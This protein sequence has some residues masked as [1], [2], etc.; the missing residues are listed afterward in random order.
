MRINGFPDHQDHRDKRADLVCPDKKKTARERARRGF[1]LAEMLITVAIIGILA[2]FGFVAVIRYQ[3]SLKQT[4]L[5]DTAR[6][7]FVAAQNHMTVSR[8]SGNW[9]TYVAEAENQPG[10]V[11]KKLGNAMG[12]GAQDSS[13]PSDYD[14]SLGSWNAGWADGKLEKDEAHDF[15]YVTV[16]ADDTNDT[17]ILSMILPNDAIDETLRG[18]GNIIIEYDSETVTV[19][20]V[21]YCKPADLKKATY[22]NT[23]GTSPES[24]IQ[25][26]ASTEAYKNQNRTSKSFRMKSDPMVGYYGGGT[27]SVK[28]G[29]VTEDSISAIIENDDR[30][31]LQVAVPEQEKSDSEATQR[32]YTVKATV[33]GQTS[34]NSREITLGKSDGIASSDKSDLKGVIS[35]TTVKNKY[36]LYFYTLDSV[37]DGADGHFAS[38][39]C[40]SASNEKPLI[41]G[42]NLTI[43]VRLVYD[44]GT[45][46][47][48]DKSGTGKKETLTAD[49]VGNS[50]TLSCNS[51]FANGSN[52]G[53]NHTARIAYGRH[54]QNLST[55]VSGVNASGNSGAQV[56][57]SDSNSS[58]IITSA[59]MLRDLDWSG[60]TIRFLSSEAIP[61]TSMGT[62]DGGGTG[63]AS[64]AVSSYKSGWN[65]SS[66]STSGST[67]AS[68]SALTGAG[69]FYSISNSALTSF[70]GNGF[71]ISNLKLGAASD[72]NASGSGTTAV[73]GNNG[74]KG[75]TYTGLFGN[76]DAGAGTAGG[77]KM[78]I[79]RLTLKNPTAEKASYAGFVV[80]KTSRVTKIQNV[81][82]TADTA[83]N[84]TA[85]QAAGGIVGQAS[86]TGTSIWYSRVLSGKT[87]TIAAISDSSS[88]ST[89]STI[90]SAAGG[91]LGSQ[92]GSQIESKTGT[93]G[94]GTG[95]SI[96]N[97]VVSIS[98]KESSTSAKSGSV[99]NDG[100]SL[101][102]TGV[103]FAGGVL[104]YC[105]GSE[106]GSSTGNASGS[107]LPYTG[108]VKINDCNVFGVGNL[109]RVSAKD[110]AAGLAAYISTSGNLDVENS[111]TSI[112]VADSDTQVNSA[113]DGFGGLIG[114][115]NS[116]E[117][118]SQISNCYVGG[119]TAGGEYKEIINDD[120]TQ[121]RYNIRGNGHVGG[122]IG[123]IAGSNLLK[124]ENCFTTA[125]AYSGSTVN[126]KN[127]NGAGTNA[128]AGSFIA[129][130]AN[131]N[132]SVTSCYATGLTNGT[133]FV[134]E[135]GSSSFSKTENNYYL[136]G[137]NKAKLTGAN[138]KGAKVGDAGTPFAKQTEVVRTNK[139]DASLKGDYPYQM[140][141]GQS[142]YYGDWVVPK[143]TQD[144]DGSFGILY[145]EIVQHGDKANATKS[146]YYHGFVGNAVPGGNAS[147]VSYKEIS[148]RTTLSD[149]QSPGD[150]NDHGLLEAPEGGEYVTE[151]GYILL[152]SDECQDEL[153]RI[154]WEEDGGSDRNTIKG[155]INDRILIQYDAITEQL[156]L[157]G[158]HAYYFN[159]ENNR[160]LTRET[161]N[162]PLFT[163]TFAMSSGTE[164]ESYNPRIWKKIISFTMNPYLADYLYPYGEWSTD[165]Q[166][167]SAHQLNILFGSFLNG[168]SYLSDEHGGYKTVTQT[169]DISYSSEI[170]FT[171]LGEKKIYKSPQIKRLGGTYQ[172]EE[173][174][175]GYRRLE[176]LS[177]PIFETIHNNE[178]SKFKNFEISNM[179][180]SSVVVNNNGEMSNLIVSHSK[181]ENS[182]LASNQNTKTILNC[183]LN[184][185]SIQGN[186]VA[187]SNSGLISNVKI[188]NAFIRKNGFVNVNDNSGTISNGEIKNAEIGDNGVAETN[189]GTIGGKN[190]DDSKGLHLESVTIGKNGFVNEN[191]GTISNSG[192]TNAQIKENGAV[193]TNSGTI[194]NENNNTI[195]GIDLKFVTIGSN[196][197]VDNN[198]G[199]IFNSE[200]VNAQI[201]ENGFANTNSKI[202]KNCQ[203]YSDNLSYPTEYQDQ[204]KEDQQYFKPDSPQVD[205]LNS[206]SKGYNLLACGL[207]YMKDTASDDGT[208]T[209]NGDIAGFVKD[210][211]KDITSCSYSGKVFGG[212]VA[213]GFFLNNSGN[214]E[215][216]YANA[217]VTASGTVAGFGYSCTGGT[218]KLCHSVGMLLQAEEGA[219][220]LYQYNN[221]SWTEGIQNDYSATWKSTVSNYYFFMK[222]YQAPGNSN[223]INNC[224]YLSSIDCDKNSLREIESQSPNASDKIKNYTYEKLKE[225][226]GY[227]SPANGNTTKPYYQYTSIDQTVYPFPMPD[228]MIAYGDWSWNKAIYSIRFEGNG[229]TP[230]INGKEISSI[231]D[232]DYVID[233]TLPDCEAPAGRNWTFVGWQDDQSGNMYKAG[234]KVSG[235]ATSGIVMLTAQWKINNEKDFNYSSNVVQTYTAQADGW[236]KLEVWGADGGNATYDATNYYAQGG[237]GGYTVNYVYLTEGQEIDV[238]VG[239]RGQ[240]ATYSQLNFGKNESKTEKSQLLNGGWNG[241]GKSYSYSSKDGKSVS[242]WL[243]GSGGGAS[244]MSL[245][246]D[247]SDNAPKTLADYSEQ[248]KSILLVAGGGGGAGLYVNALSKI[249]D[250]YPAANMGGNGGGNPGSD[251]DGNGKS[252]NTSD[253]SGTFG[254]GGTV[255]SGGIVSGH[256]SKSG[257]FGL[258]GSPV[259]DTDTDKYD[260]GAGGG[261]GWYGGGSSYVQTEHV[262]PS[263]GGGS[264]YFKTSDSTFSIAN[265]TTMQG[266]TLVGGNSN[267]PTF[268]SSDNGNGNGHG[269]I[270]YLPSYS[271]SVTVN[272]NV[273]TPHENNAVTV[274][275]NSQIQIRLKNTQ[276]QSVNDADWTV[277]VIYGNNIPSDRGSLAGTGNVRTF[278]SSSAGTYVITATGPEKVVSASVTIIVKEAEGDDSNAITGNA[279]A[280]AASG[281]NSG[282]TANRNA[283][284]STAGSTESTTG[285]ETSEDSKKGSDSSSDSAGSVDESSSKKVDEDRSDESIVSSSSP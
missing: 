282:Q 230:V 139:Y 62:S 176:Y 16:S 236:Y 22:T 220:F 116:N 70:N 130:S 246:S 208:N 196:G 89:S 113:S 151:D 245:H 96:E 213:A 239:G 252:N 75:S 53:D 49:S 203:L 145:Y 126:V 250:R 121:G 108:A 27:S 111:A 63:A 90:G 170:K 2:A 124:I 211:Q 36:R 91:I 51:L 253:N 277:K 161:W 264:G 168:G 175:K 150:I 50:V 67:S 271:L 114:Y 35:Q 222:S 26:V 136:S 106:P 61:R 20:G 55:V 19:Y 153:F 7:I 134:G 179:K 258:G 268:E 109:D 103:S 104:G 152:V 137:V 76:I 149:T 65:T 251:L 46:N 9:D 5:D 210:N 188:E 172:G 47:K 195:R 166:I 202:I 38:Q 64:Y 42:E 133:V 184:D 8:A 141:S 32:K 270:T 275:K 74:L 147:N 228:G 174:S 120:S 45:D 181:F 14:G 37:T 242:Y 157:E 144:I 278:S 247:T 99:G 207:N 262:A 159:T 146:A 206:D 23:T 92:I 285:A 85:D 57:G 21:W 164:D 155:L 233:V 58:A 260:P 40:N 43:T 169:M 190:G 115:V 192:V 265:G 173:L 257:T 240:D 18:N 31:M 127:G 48:N 232:I 59:K 226:S 101:N 87:L 216:S 200:I 142:V 41:P 281:N 131:S 256:L 237:E 231:D 52:S 182:A 244:H 118:G 215:S 160:A 60:M 79:Q 180:A 205:D 194:G 224:A 198:S 122:F 140:I 71:A 39:F 11:A 4:E 283:E 189:R 272:N 29:G 217:L 100:E 105:A 274:S 219:G 110:A 10:S 249:V 86:S 212:N 12:A 95:L 135:N 148:T 255:N 154:G 263:A 13:G 279:A 28:K 107:N 171:E 235:L 238:Y 117:G 143:N 221:S 177:Q 88:N 273:V 1:T 191:T 24:V 66:V 158:Y 204:Y 119:R 209:E 72:Q 199:S 227:G 163:I 186:G 102:I 178:N 223:Q 225:I 254:T 93:A 185:V 82:V 276:N 243:F 123:Q 284:E 54:L 167:R 165:Y 30:L 187:T 98:G 201:G 33:T 125:S 83:L 266:E 56:S 3:K 15:R 218:V 84:L 80:G 25:S 234:E 34:G 269:R 94:T 17:G 73:A 248:Q 78:E 229:G 156:N 241:G 259:A 44:D 214:I 69:N 112:Y 193:G 129:N 280:N 77:S 267:I 68:T 261:G 128:Q 97:C 138:V 162:D 183:S 6:E 132:L 81:M 197:F